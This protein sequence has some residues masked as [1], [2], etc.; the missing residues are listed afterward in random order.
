MPVAKA[1]SPNLNQDILL[2]LFFFV[3]MMIFPY[4]VII[5]AGHL[6][7]GDNLVA[8]LLQW[9]ATFAAV[10]TC[11]VRRIPLRDF[12]WRWPGS[13][14]AIAYVLPLI[15]A[16]PVYLGTW[17]MLAGSFA[18]QAFE[19]EAA[20]TYGFPIWP[21]F[22]AFGLSIPIL[23]TSGV[24]G[25]IANALGEEIGLR[26][27]LLPRLVERFGFGIG[28]L[29]CGCLWA[30]WHYPAMLWTDYNAGKTPLYTV[31]CFTLTVIGVSILYAWLRQRSGSLWPA[32]MAH[33]AHNLFVQAV[34][35]PMTSSSGWAPYITSEFGCGMVVTVGILV[36]IVLRK[37]K[38]PYQGKEFANF[39]GGDAA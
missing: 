28:S 14:M 32:A 11:G 38:N 3:L 29:V 15:Y 36:A 31:G 13:Y 22:A 19:H 37:S 9:T 18:P 34:L 20:V 12:G 6:R 23:A 39:N 8:R 2:F 10:A 17:A 5:H 35:D 33:A 24:I 4:A 16:L 27:F 25:S 1:S 7:V 30:L 26:G 21:R